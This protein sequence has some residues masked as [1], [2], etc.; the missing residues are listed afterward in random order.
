MLVITF[1]VAKDMTG[2]AH[3]FC[4]AASK[5]HIHCSHDNDAASFSP[6][7]WYDAIATFAA[8][9]FAPL[10]FTLRVAGIYRRHAIPATARRGQS[11]IQYRLHYWDAYH[12]FMPRKFRFDEYF[13][14]IDKHFAPLRRKKCISTATASKIGHM[15][16]RRPRHVK[17]QGSSFFPR[18]RPAY[19]LSAS[20]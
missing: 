9:H 14:I 15:A 20:I 17:R 5:I 4:I 1:R 18:H 19:A 10:I 6:L 3:L 13:H 16:S 7:A 11:L 8:L 12:Y 2:R